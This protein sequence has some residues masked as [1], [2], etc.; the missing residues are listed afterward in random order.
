M[1]YYPAIYSQDSVWVCAPLEQRCQITPG[2]PGNLVSGHPKVQRK[3]NDHSRVIRQLSAGQPREN[4]LRADLGGFP[5]VSAK[6]DSK[7]IAIDR[8]GAIPDTRALGPI[9]PSHPLTCL[10]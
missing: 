1:A 10:S 5:L 8:A 7:S 9:R 6:A 4:L 3:E 2:Q